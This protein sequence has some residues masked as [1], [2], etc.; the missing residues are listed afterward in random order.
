MER[1]YYSIFKTQMF[2]LLYLIFDLVQS[3]LFAGNGLE[4]FT[5]TLNNGVL[6]MDCGTYDDCYSLLCD[7]EIDPLYYL[8]IVKAKYWDGNCDKLDTDFYGPIGAEFDT[9]HGNI[10]TG[11]YIINNV[12]QASILL[13]KLNKNESITQIQ[14]YNYG[15]SCLY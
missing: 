13:C 6:K 10:M 11:Q 2:A 12:S 3:N 5:Y 4:T 8:I 7:L 1:L 15:G 9:Y 14:Y